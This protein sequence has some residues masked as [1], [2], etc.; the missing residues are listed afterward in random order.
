MRFFK[1]P[2]SYG[3]YK[4]L[5]DCFGIYE[6]FWYAKIYLRFMRLFWDLLDFFLDFLYFFDFLRFWKYEI[7][8]IYGFLEFIGQAYEIFYFKY[9][10]PRSNVGASHEL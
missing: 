10:T 2:E 1:T 5:W 8:E 9:F 6:I 4:D 3:I 7:N